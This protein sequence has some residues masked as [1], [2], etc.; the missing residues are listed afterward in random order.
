MAKKSKTQKAKAAAARA[1]KKAEQQAQELKTEEVVA[2]ATEEVSSRKEKK[3]AKKAASSAAA[4]KK[5]AKKA[6]KE[7]PKKKRFKFLRE[8]RAELRRVTWPSRKDVGRWSLVVVG[9]LLFFG[10]FVLILDNAI[11][12]PLLVAFSGLGA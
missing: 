2:E 3:A 4:E 6:E 12:T 1:Q 10:V 7:Q 8:V 9:A 11:V 5:P